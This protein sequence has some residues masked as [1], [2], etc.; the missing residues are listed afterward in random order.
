VHGGRVVQVGT[1]R[2]RIA[3]TQ[4]QRVDV[5]PGA[6]QAAAQA[7]AQAL[8]ASPPG[9]PCVDLA[10]TF[11][12]MPG[13]DIEQL[14]TDRHCFMV[15]RGWPRAAATAGE[16]AAEGRPPRD[17][18]RVAVHD[19]PAGTLLQRAKESPPAPV[20]GLVPFARLQAEDVPTEAGRWFVGTAG[21]YE[22]WLLLKVADRAGGERFIGAPWSTCA[23]WRLGREVQQANPAV[24]VSQAGASKACEGRR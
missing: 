10:A 12:V 24:G 23:L 3:A 1:R 8:R 22:G 4:A 17:E 5:E 15:A 9:S 2:W 6:L 13:F 16:A 11:A 14:E 19:K 21:L 18:L 20:A 7:Q